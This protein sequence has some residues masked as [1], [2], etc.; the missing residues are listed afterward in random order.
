MRYVKIIDSEKHVDQSLF[1]KIR[2][3]LA[4]LSDLLDSWTN[5]YGDQGTITENPEIVAAEANKM[6]TLHIKRMEAKGLSADVSDEEF[7]AWW[8]SR[9]LDESR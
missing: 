2:K 5:N 8:E 4:Y 9:L 3:D 7:V 6:Q 1:L